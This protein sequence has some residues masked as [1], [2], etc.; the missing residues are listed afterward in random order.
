MLRAARSTVDVEVARSDLACTIGCETSGTGE[1]H[2]RSGP[3]EALREDGILSMQLRFA[4][5]SIT[6]ARIHIHR[7]AQGCGRSVIQGVLYLN[8]E[9]K[10]AGHARS[11]GDRPRSIQN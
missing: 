3:L 1:A 2:E 10:G 5:R 11:S 6:G 8:R 7:N 9:I 4:P